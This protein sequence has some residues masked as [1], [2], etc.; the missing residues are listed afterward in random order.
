MQKLKY[1]HRF[2]FGYFIVV[3]GVHDTFFIFFFTY[4]RPTLHSNILII[5]DAINVKMVCFLCMC[6]RM[7]RCIDT[8]RLFDQKKLPFHFNNYHCQVLWNFCI[9]NFN[10]NGNKAFTHF[11]LKHSYTEWDSQIQT[12]TYIS[13]LYFT[14]LVFCFILV[15][16]FFFIIAMFDLLTPSYMCLVYVVAHSIYHPHHDAFTTF[17]WEGR[18]RCRASNGILHLLVLSGRSYAHTHTYIHKRHS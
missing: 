4:W 13:R 2:C 9:L 6:M 3:Y 14:L 12:Q 10:A 15:A 1:G 8:L 17:G 11:T 7:D 18:N 5:S 16:L